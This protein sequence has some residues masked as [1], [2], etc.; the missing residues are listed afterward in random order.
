MLVTAHLIRCLSISILIRFSRPL[1]DIERVAR[2]SL[3]KNPRVSGIATFSAINRTAM[4]TVAYLVGGLVVLVGSFL[5]TNWI[6]SRNDGVNWKFT[7]E[8]SLATAA[9]AAGYQPSKDL[10]GH[11]DTVARIGP[12]RVRANG[13]AA[14][15]AGDG[16]PI[17]L[18]VFI[19]GREVAAFRTKGP[20]PDI[21]AGIN[22]NPNASPDAAKNTLFVSELSC[23][24]GDMLFVVATT[25]KKS[26]ALLPPAPT[27][28]P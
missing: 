16:S 5:I 8:A 11:V 14:D 1:R 10:G 25:A 2:T 12:G 7:D 18:N 21:T 19:N 20:R 9:K 15:L 13:W 17:A 26:Y 3:L 4:R 22:A 6:L 24:S 23:A 27:P 28:C